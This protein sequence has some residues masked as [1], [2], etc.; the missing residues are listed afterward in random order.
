MK[1]VEY[2]RRKLAAKSTRVGVRYQYYEMRHALR[3]MSISTPPG[4]ERWQTC[5]GWCGKAVDSVADRLRVRG[6]EDDLFGVGEIYQLNNQDILLPAAELCHMG[7]PS[8]VQ[9]VTNC[10]HRAIGGGGFGYRSI[11]DGVDVAL[12]ESAVLAFWACANSKPKK[13]QRISY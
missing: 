11:V 7:Q 10:E 6:F 2:L 8:M 1:G 5:L 13:K 12:L 4:L 3:D 9:S